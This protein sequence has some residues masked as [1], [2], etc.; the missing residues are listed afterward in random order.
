[1]NISDQYVIKIKVEKDELSVWFNEHKT[2]LGKLKKFHAD[3]NNDL[4]SLFKSTDK[5]FKDSTS[6]SIK[7][8]SNQLKSNKLKLDDLLPE[9][10][11][12]KTG[13]NL[14][15]L[16]L[17]DTQFLDTEENQPIQKEHFKNINDINHDNGLYDTLPDF[18]KLSDYFKSF[19]FSTY[20]ENYKVTLEIA[21]KI[22]DNFNTMLA[23]SS[24]ISED[25][26]KISSMIRDIINSI[27]ST[28][29]F[30]SSIF[31]FVSSF[32]PGVGGLGAALSGLPYMNTHVPSSMYYRPISNINVP[33]PHIFIQGTPKDYFEYKVVKKGNEEMRIR[34]HNLL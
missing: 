4:K 13:Y 24:F 23:S 3:F 28:I 26:A 34:G 1:M 25:F 15:N 8:F 30:G 21:D 27:S 11:K 32:I 31:D 22:K 20:E 5:Y 9:D 10:L 33:A 7:E 19:D 18:D 29:N 2:I 17:P 12:R 6:N 14:N 16:P